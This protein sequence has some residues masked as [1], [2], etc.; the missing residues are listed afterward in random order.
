LDELKSSKMTD[1]V[2]ELFEIRTAFYLGN[3]NQCI[4][5]ANKLKPSSAEKKLERDVFMYRAYMAQRKFGV[6]LDEIKADG[7]AAQ[8]LAAVR[9]FAEFLAAPAERREALAAA[10]DKA[11]TSGVDDV[12]GPLMAANIHFYDGNHEAA[13]RCLNGA[14]TSKEA[15]EAMALTIQILLSIDRVDLAKKELKK[16]QDSDDDAILTQLALA[17]FNLAVGGDKLQDAFYIFQEMADK[18]GS[19]PLLLNGQA[20]ALI[21]QGKLDDA[22]PI[23]QEALDKDANHAET[24]INLVVLSQGLGKSPETAS[25]YMSQLKDSHAA[26]PFVKNAVAKEAEFDRLARNYAPTVTA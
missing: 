4:Y 22:E 13:L 18:H 10:A 9:R 14:G 5:E 16:M 1:G 26:H 8:E 17:W 15:L 6:V 7:G 3:Y 25:R 24:L 11:L 2:D 20:A 12:I 23:L 19:T 21:A